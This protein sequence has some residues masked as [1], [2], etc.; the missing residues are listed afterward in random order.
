MNG[1]NFA[2]ALLPKT[3]FIASVPK[4]VKIEIATDATCD[5]NNREIARASNA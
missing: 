4:Y 3:T 5:L 1:K 2:T